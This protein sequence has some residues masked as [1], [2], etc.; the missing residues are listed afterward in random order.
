[1]STPAE[2]MGGQSPDAV[3]AE[4]VAAGAQ[5]V[6]VDVAAL[7]ARIAA[8]EAQQA[9]SPSGPRPPGADLADHVAA[10]LAAHPNHDLSALTEK[11]GADLVHA[12][13]ALA[14]R[15]PDLDLSYVLQLAREAA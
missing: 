14:G 2:P 8:L 11:S 3:T 10:K 15:H 1:M 12:V 4:A 7:Q 13:E 5:P 9:A 6:E